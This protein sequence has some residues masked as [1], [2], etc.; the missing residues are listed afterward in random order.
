MVL[1]MLN[2]TTAQSVQH[3]V[4]MLNKERLGSAA[5]TLHQIMKNQPENI[6]AWYWLAQTY[7]K[8]NRISEL[9]DTLLK[10]PGG[11]VSSPLVRAVNG[12]IFLVE[13]KQQQAKEQFDLALK[14]TKHKDPAVLRA[15]AY[16]HFASD[17]GKASEAL[18]LVN[19]A[20]KRD[21]KNP[22]LYILL[23]DINRKLLNGSEAYRAYEHALT[24]DRN[25]A[26]AKYKLG[27]TSLPKITRK[28]T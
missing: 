7:L 1:V 8:Q 24:L 27:K 14:D 4:S 20:I 21:K 25:N 18:D 17:S 22:E 3:A 16:A 28:C 9:K 13:N 5:S 23:G 26:I 15:I 11:V 12:Q 10:M 2:T 6:H 19:K